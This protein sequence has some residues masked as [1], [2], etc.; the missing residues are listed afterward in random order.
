MKNNKLMVSVALAFAGAASLVEA[1]DLS[2]DPTLQS[3]R[4]ISAEINMS[5]ALEK[6]GLLTNSF[7][8]QGKANS[9][10]T[11]SQVKDAYVKTF[12]DVIVSKTNNGD[13]CVEINEYIQ[14]QVLEMAFAKYEGKFSEPAVRAKTSFEKTASEYTLARCHQLQD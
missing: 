12:D 3:A 1:S 2:T 13:T 6:F 10:L 9:L 8:E 7:T 4:V 14:H 5:S 11:A